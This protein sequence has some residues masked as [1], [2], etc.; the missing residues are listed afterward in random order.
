MLA[1]RPHAGVFCMAE[2]TDSTEDRPCKLSFTAISVP[3]IPHRGWTREGEHLSFIS[4][5]APP[6]SRSRQ[7]NAEVKLLLVSEPATGALSV[8]GPTGDVRE[9]QLMGRHG[10]CLGSHVAHAL[11]WEQ[12]APLLEVLLKPTFFRNIEPMRLT[13]IVA[14]QSLDGIAHD[15]IVWHLALAIRQLNG[16]SEMRLLE[17]MVTSL[18]KRI[19]NSHGERYAPKS[20]S[21]LSEDRTQAV[22]DYM[23]ENLGRS[24]VAKELGALVGISTQHFTELFR[25]RT[26][27][28]PIEYLRELRRMEAHK[29][30]LAGE[31]RMGEIADA[32]GFCG[33]SHLSNEFKKFFGYTARLLRTRGESA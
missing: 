15:H 30:I 5:K 25:N 16:H 31:L 19:I 10:V 12:E 3:P 2:Q 4:E 33:E 29:M 13:A 14:R 22:V 24:I 18:A 11:H 21:R 9:I 27:K 17:A 23:E 6:E 26:G 32:C 1:F 28:P 20:G 8:W 7:S